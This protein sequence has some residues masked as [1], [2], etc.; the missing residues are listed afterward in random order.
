MTTH[1]N[2]PSPVDYLERD[3]ACLKFTRRYGI[4]LT[5][6]LSEV[7]FGGKDATHVLPKLVEKN[8]I[9]RHARKIPGGLSYGTLT[10]QGLKVIGLECKEATPPTGVSLNI[11]VALSWYCCLEVF[12]RFRLLPEEI[13]RLLGKRVPSNVPHILDNSATGPVVLRVYHSLGQVSATKGP[14]EEFFDAANNRPSVAAW[15]AAQQY[16]LLVLCPTREKAAQVN[17]FLERKGLLAHGRLIVGLGPTTETLSRY[18][19]ERKA[20]NGEDRTRPA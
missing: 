16:G 19:C 6:T 11:S 8:W 15:V 10:P 7:F 2:R 13:T 18:L 3:L 20:A 14:V 1:Q 9:T 17:A 12:R 5:S 4:C